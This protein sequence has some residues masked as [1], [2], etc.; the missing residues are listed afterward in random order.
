MTLFYVEPSIAMPVNLPFSFFFLPPTPCLSHWVPPCLQHKPW[1]LTAYG[2]WAC[3][4]VLGT[5]GTAMVLIHTTISFCVAQFRSPFLSWLCSLFLLSTLR[6]QDVE[7]VMVRV[8]V[9]PL[10]RR[11]PLW[12]CLYPG[13]C[14]CFQTRENWRTVVA[15]PLVATGGWC[16][17]TLV[18]RSAVFC[19]WLCLSPW[20]LPSADLVPFLPVWAG[21][22]GARCHR[23]K[24]GK[25]AICK[26]AK[27][28]SPM[29]L[30]KQSS[31]ECCMVYR[32][33]S[34]SL[35]H[36]KPT[37]V[38]EQ[39]RQVFSLHRTPWEAFDILSLVMWNWASHGVFIFV[40]LFTHLFTFSLI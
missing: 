6:L 35:S 5:Q 22:D 17:W 34:H 24:G 8:S 10:G 31:I 37:I 19:I 40:H 36:Q 25:K 28:K 33:L 29:H 32:E 1:I 18:L 23:N 13:R 3:W 21:M 16:M 14:L 7:E 15:L 11:R 4:C 27:K 39:I 9:L 30:I 12:Q 20:R 2:M 26:K 38:P